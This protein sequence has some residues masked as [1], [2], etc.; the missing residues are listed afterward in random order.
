MHVSV[1][2]FN[3]S[4][5]FSRIRWDAE[6]ET[7]DS[8]A[9]TAG[10]R[11]FAE[12]WM[13]TDATALSLES[14]ATSSPLFKAST[15]RLTAA[16]S[17]YGPDAVDLMIDWVSRE[18]TERFRVTYLS[19]TSLRCSGLRGL[20]IGGEL[21]GHELTHSNNGWRHALLF[22]GNEFAIVECES[23]QYAKLP[24]SSGEA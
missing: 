21:L 7:W 14:I 10:V 2:T 22:I 13:H 1:E 12:Q 19:A 6:A 17:D 4:A 11:R 18:Q 24:V 20:L 16:K 5:L 23:I 9:Y 3:P 8:A 15:Y